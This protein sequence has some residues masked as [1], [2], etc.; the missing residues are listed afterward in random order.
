MPVTLLCS[1]I[2]NYTKYHCQLVTTTSLTTERHHYS[3]YLRWIQTAS[4]LQLA[5]WMEFGINGCSLK[6]PDTFCGKLFILCLFM[7]F[8]NDVVNSGDNLALMVRM[9]SE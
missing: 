3:S 5:V 9:I 4:V 7:V 8:F 2:H 1:L 6:T